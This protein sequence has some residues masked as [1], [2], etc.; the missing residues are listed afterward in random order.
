[1]QTP[2]TTSTPVAVSSPVVKKKSKGGLTLRQLLV[3]IATISLVLGLLVHFLITYLAFRDL[4]DSYWTERLQ[5]QAAATDGLMGWFLSE[6]RE[7]SY[8]GWVKEQLE[9]A[10]VSVYRI[11]RVKD[12]NGNETNAI[13]SIASQPTWT[14]RDTLPML[15]Q[16]KLEAALGDLK[17]EGPEFQFCNDCGGYRTVVYR[18]WNNVIMMGI[19][20]SVGNQRITQF[21]ASSV[22]SAVAAFLVALGLVATLS[23]ALTRPLAAL[24][25]RTARLETP[26][27]IPGLERRDEVGLLARALESGL[28]GLKQARETEKQFLAAASHELRTPITALVMGLERDL[29]KPR[30]AEE[31]REALRRAHRTALRLSDMSGNLLTLN[32]AGVSGQPRIELNLLEIA[33]QVADEQM[34][35]AVNKGLYIELGGD[36]VSF[37]GDPGAVRQVVSNLVSNSIKFTDAGFVRVTLHKSLEWATLIVED[38][39]IG[40]PEDPAEA[41]SLLEP[42]RRSSVVASTRPG[43]GLGLAVV[44]EVAKAHGGTIELSR[45]VGGGTKVVVTFRRPLEMIEERG[46]RGEGSGG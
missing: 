23:L 45:R 43:A 13:T 2:F 15:D 33:A 11:S 27:P 30:S 1:M 40:I 19:P 24:A 36:S 38:S 46:K 25:K 41:R 35:V 20:A 21:W 3:T 9:P 39:G 42:F 37:P 31:A 12:P 4:N 8:P 18:G 44:A 28:A 10:V 26:D 17:A 6:P 14:N 16:T 32:R 34:P 22:G 7:E 29:A 5:R